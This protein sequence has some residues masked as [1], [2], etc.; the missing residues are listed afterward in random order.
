MLVLNVRNSN[1]GSNESNW[2]PTFFTISTKTMIIRTNLPHNH[3]H[4]GVFM[5]ATRS[6]NSWIYSNEMWRPAQWHSNVRRSEVTA[7]SV[8]GRTSSRQV[9][10]GS[11]RHAFFSRCSGPSKRGIIQHR[12]PPLH[13]AYV[14]FGG[15]DWTNFVKMN[16]CP[17]VLDRGHYRYC[18]MHE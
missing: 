11:A 15:R 5:T 7:V 16:T 4:P 8:S 10:L 1:T 14:Q 6:C 12:T 9:S 3:V 2:S 18:R 13:F 17:N